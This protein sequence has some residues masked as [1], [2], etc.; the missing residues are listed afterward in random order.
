ML[1]IIIKNEIIMPNPNN[2]KLRQA[3]AKG[4]LEEVKTLLKNP[5]DINEQS[6]NG[7]TALHWAV[8]KYGECK[9]EPLKT[10]YKD[11]I[12]L[13]I[14]SGADDTVLNG[15]KCSIY[16]LAIQIKT[17]A[18][19]QG[20]F[21]WWLADC[22]FAKEIE[23]IFSD[24]PD[25]KAEHLKALQGQCAIFFTHLMMLPM[26]QAILRYFK[27]EKIVEIISLGAGL[28]VDAIALMKFAKLF[29]KEIRYYAVDINV[30]ETKKISTKYPNHV[31]PIKVDATDIA[32]LHTK[33]ERKKFSFGLLR[34]PDFTQDN[35]RLALFQDMLN[36]SLAECLKDN[37]IFLSTFGQQK[38]LENF[39]QTKSISGPNACYRKE[40]TGNFNELVP[41]K[42]VIAVL[43]LDQEIVPHDK[44]SVLLSFNEAEYKRSIA[45]PQ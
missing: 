20:A 39:K 22:A 38:E 45:A 4:Q 9:E 16:H 1:V 17:H 19:N 23:R 32:A 31:I 3:A 8:K 29:G 40:F 27:E 42:G 43:T 36:V 21:V 6:A 7:N 30:K 37:G 12:N 11:I 2:V 13:L 44:Y 18:E 15:D 28:C 33:L 10:S 24:D 25:M 26:A 14:A 35:G 5:V 41:T 34:N